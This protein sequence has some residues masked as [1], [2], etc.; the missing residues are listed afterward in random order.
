MNGGLRRL[1]GGS[2]FLAWQQE[3]EDLLD[4]FGFERNWPALEGTTEVVPALDLSETENSVDVKLDI[5]GYKPEDIDIQIRGNLLTIKG[6][7]KE[8]KEEK[9]RSYHR[10]ERASGSF[11]RT[12]ALPCDVIEKDAKAEY[13][14]GVLSLTM[15]KTEPVK[16]VKV[17]V[18]PAS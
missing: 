15:P 18:K 6:S 4:R 9:G 14:D 17:A 16:A 11:T 8:E 5:P 2:P 1:F 10:I 3:M 7:K 12:V 13:K